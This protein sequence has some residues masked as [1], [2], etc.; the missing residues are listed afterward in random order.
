MAFYVTPVKR[1][2]LALGYIFSAWI[3]GTFMCLLTFAMGEVFFFLKGYDMLSVKDALT[4]TGMIM[5]SALT[6]SSIGYVIALF[7]HS[8]S[9]WSGILTIIGTLVGFAGGIYLPMSQL[10]IGVQKILKA[11]PILH[12]VSMMRAV[13]TQQIVEQTFAGMPDGLIPVYR[14]KM[15]ITVTVA[16][17]IWS[18]REQVL[19]LMAY[20]F[21]AIILAVIVTRNRKLKDR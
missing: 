4:L 12:S 5:C 13:S 3:I 9:A 18:I 17:N 20:T 2:Y 11:L 14:D 16:G 21:C 6:Y 15:G 1:L 7:V 8:N 19:L 10:S